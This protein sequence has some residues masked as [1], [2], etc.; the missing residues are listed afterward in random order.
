MATD[1]HTDHLDD[2]DY[3]WEFLRRSPDYRSDFARLQ[4]VR[5][6]VG[7]AQA[8]MTELEIGRRWGLRFCRG[9]DGPRDRR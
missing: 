8:A 1:E 7:D 3:A 6:E 9:P 4:N 5:T 2:P